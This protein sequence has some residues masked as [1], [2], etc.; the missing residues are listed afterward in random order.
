M[1]VEQSAQ[2]EH[3]VSPRLR[4]PLRVSPPLA[5]PPRRERDCQLLTLRWPGEK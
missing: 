3:V 2:L 4:I 5:E 1:R